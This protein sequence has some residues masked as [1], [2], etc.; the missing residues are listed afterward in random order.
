MLPLSR[1]LHSAV[2]CSF[3]YL[4]LDRSFFSPEKSSLKG[5]LIAVFY[6]LGAKEY[7]FQ[8]ST[9]KLIEI[10]VRRRIKKDFYIKKIFFMVKVVKY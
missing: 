9:V 4:V 2:Q 8:R 6:Y 3:S 7:A 10:T 5:Q 1:M